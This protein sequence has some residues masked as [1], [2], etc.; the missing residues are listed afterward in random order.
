[1][2]KEVCCWVA[3]ILLCGCTPPK[4]LTQADL[5]GT[6][7][8]DPTFSPNQRYVR[9]NDFYHFRLLLNQDGTFIARSVPPDLF[10]HYHHTPAAREQRGSW[11]LKRA[12][13]SDGRY[14]L[15][16]SFTTM[17][18]IHSSLTDWKQGRLV[19]GVSDDGHAAFSLTK[20][21]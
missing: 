8:I 15:R 1:M 11:T 10:F 16:L 20:E 19:I 2:R 5:A 14:Y 6:W 9:P 17:R 12:P 18:G 3:T 21:Q 7:R 4:P 13:D